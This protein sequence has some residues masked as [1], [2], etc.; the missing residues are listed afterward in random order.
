MCMTSERKRLSN[1]KNATKSTGPRSQRGKQFSSTNALKHGLY[2]SELRI[3]EDERPEFEALRSGLLGQLAPKTMLQGIAF[4]Q[5]LSSCWRCKIALRIE[6]QQ[7]SRGSLN[8]RAKTADENASELEGA[9]LQWFGVSSQDLQRG[10][11]FLNELRSEVAT[12]GALHLEDRKQQIVKLFGE[13]FYEALSEWKPMSVD[14]ILMAE[15][16]VEHAR[17]FGAGRSD[18]HGSQ[19]QRM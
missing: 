11:K 13:P 7:P 15:H 18:T 6:M 8:E 5:I 16:S 17:R 4:E 19:I 3:A 1:A 14:A 2:S 12:S 9:Q 10:I